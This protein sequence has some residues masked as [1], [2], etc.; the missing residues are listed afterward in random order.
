MKPRANELTAGIFVLAMLFFFLLFL[1]WIGGGIAR[2][3]AETQ[4]AVTWFNNIGGLKEKVVVVYQG[5][6]IGEVAHIDFDPQNKKIRV[7]MDLSKKFQLPSKGIAT[8]TTASLLGDPYIEITTEYEDVHGL[9]IRGDDSIKAVD[10]VYQIDAIDPAS[11]GM[12]QVQLKRLLSK[13]EG[14]LD[15][16]SD[17]LGQVLNG[18]NLLV[19]DSRFRSNLHVTAQNFAIASAKLP[20]A[21]DDA[22]AML[23]SA[24]RAVGKVD[25][26]LTRSEDTIYNILRNVDE[27]GVNARTLSYGLA[28]S[29]WMLVWKDKTWEDKVLRRD[30]SILEGSLRKPPLPSSTDA[31]AGGGSLFSSGSASTE[32]KL[33]GGNMYR[34]Y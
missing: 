25:T 26:M 21:M 27:I 19:S 30:T 23:R 1:S 22:Q 2:W 3:F 20:G 24:N 28:Q 10:G 31:S 16:L 17:T 18:A 11:F 7:N 5:L 12:L 4:P 6:P 9:L 13:A 29:P 32:P 14:H 15:E 33:S 34:H 8:I